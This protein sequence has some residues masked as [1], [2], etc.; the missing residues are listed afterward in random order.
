MTVRQL[1][2]Q[3]QKYQQDMPVAICGDI[4]YPPEEHTIEISCRTWEDSNFPW[5]LPDFDYVNLE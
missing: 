5:N 1:I 3:L 4:Y 2:E